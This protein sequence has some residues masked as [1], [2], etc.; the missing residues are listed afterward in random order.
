MAEV[1]VHTQVRTRSR[2]WQAEQ[3]LKNYVFL[4]NGEDNLRIYVFPKN[5]KQNLR[6]YEF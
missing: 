3:N 6:I 5:G 1:L 4:K 2:E